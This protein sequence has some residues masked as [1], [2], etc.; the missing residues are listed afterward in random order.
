MIQSVAGINMVKIFYNFF[1][2]RVVA[3]F[4]ILRMMDVRGVQHCHHYQKRTEYSFFVTPPSQKRRPILEM[5]IF[6]DPYE[7]AMHHNQQLKSI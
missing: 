1:T 6:N 3:A 4:L 7:N 5:L 2:I